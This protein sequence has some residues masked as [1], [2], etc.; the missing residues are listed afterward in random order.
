MALNQR[1]PWF[2][3]HPIPSNLPIKYI[4]APHDFGWENAGHKEMDEV[5]PFW[6]MTNGRSLGRKQIPKCLILD[7]Q[8]E[9]E[10]LVLLNWW[11]SRTGDQQ[12]E[13]ASYQG[14]Q[15]YYRAPKRS[16]S[17]FQYA[18]QRYGKGLHA[19]DLVK[20]HEQR[21]DREARVE[22][23]KELE[24]AASQKAHATALERS[25][26]QGE[27]AATPGTPTAPKKSVVGMK[28]SFVSCTLANAPLG[29]R[30][31]Q[32]TSDLVQRFNLSMDILYCARTIPE[33]CAI[34]DC[35]YPALDQ[36]R[37]CCALHKQN[38]WVRK[39]G[40]QPQRRRGHLLLGPEYATRRTRDDV[41]V[42]D[43]SHRVKPVPCGCSSELCEAIGWSADTARVPKNCELPDG[44]IPGEHRDKDRPLRLAPWHFPPNARLQLPDGS[45]I[46]VFGPK[47]EDF[48]SPDYDISKFL[49][50]PGMIEYQKRKSLW[51]LPEWVYEMQDMEQG[52]QTLGECQVAEFRKQLKTLMFNATVAALSRKDLIQSHS[53]VNA[54]LQA[55]K[56]NYTDKKRVAVTLSHRKRRLAETGAVL[57]TGTQET[58]EDEN[59]RHEEDEDCSH[60]E[61]AH[62]SPPGMAGTPKLIF[63]RNGSSVLRPQHTP[64]YATG[65]GL[66]P[67]STEAARMEDAATRVWGHYYANYGRQS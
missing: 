17:P 13:I 16:A 43:G 20:E 62:P 59:S 41:A 54:K 7:S 51:Q 2:K 32:T 37:G 9:S 57:G 35:V 38:W 33:D 63:A 36:N 50:E 49:K 24:Q 22:L 26:L 3:D 42:L 52:P 39:I 28:T 4:K 40:A 60:S 61:S 10:R 27:P 30:A 21:T 48:V 45:W 53:E 47:P 19:L 65:G 6:K 5:F 14:L 1:V 44:L 15:R 11:R 56:R 29:F 25:F 58:D 64:L 8:T 34:E 12:V 67:Y 46:V 66:H 18:Q 23:A 55:M 31:M